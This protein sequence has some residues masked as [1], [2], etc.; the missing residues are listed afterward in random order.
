MIWNPRR[1]LFYTLP[2]S[3]VLFCSCGPYSF[4]GTNISPDVKTIFVDNFFNLSGNGPADLSQIFSEGLRETYQQNTNLELLM[5]S[6]DLSINGEIL[7][8]DVLP[9]APSGDEVAA[10]NRLKIR[11]R[12]N[13][14]NK[15]NPE[16]D[17]ENK[18]FS[19]FSDFPQQ[20]N[21]QD[22]EEELIEEIFSQI[23]LEIYTE[24]VANW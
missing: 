6:A 16:Q 17:F 12:V 15:V 14:Y 18:E 19:F 11:V 1:F 13:Y 5:E 21:L 23:F 7:S 20:Q 3:F 24:T 10:I 2:V 4:T 8:Y 22:V 9:I